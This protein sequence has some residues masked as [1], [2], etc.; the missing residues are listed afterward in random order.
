[1]TLKNLCKKARLRTSLIPDRQTLHFADLSAMM[2][3]L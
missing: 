1:M 3:N 2:P